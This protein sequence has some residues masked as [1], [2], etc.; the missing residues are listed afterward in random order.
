MMMTAIYENSARNIKL[1]FKSYKS[2]DNFF[3]MHILPSGTSRRIREL[4]VSSTS[5]P[6]E[7]FK[8]CNMHKVMLMKLTV[9]TKHVAC[10]TP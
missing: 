1:C 8:Y 10:L 7:S 4:H 2:V 3:Y 5:T 6:R 9:K